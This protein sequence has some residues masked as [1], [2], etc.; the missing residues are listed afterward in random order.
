MYNVAFSFHIRY[1]KYEKIVWEAEAMLHTLMDL[2]LHYYPHLLLIYVLIKTFPA[3]NV[4]IKKI[5]PA[6]CS[7]FLLVLW[8]WIGMRL[9]GQL[10]SGGTE[11]F[12]KSLISLCYIGTAV[13]FAARYLE[14]WFWYKLTLIMMWWFFWGAI[15]SLLFAVAIL[16]KGNE[17]M[18]WI[19][20]ILFENDVFLTIFSVFL[21]WL[22]VSSTIKIP[23]KICV[24]ISVL[25]F[26]V[27]ES[28]IFTDSNM[29]ELRELHFLHKE[30]VIFTLLIS[31]MVFTYYCI[32]LLLKH[33]E[34]LMIQK[35][36][37][38][39][40]KMELQSAEMLFAQNRK[41]SHD[42][43]N[44]MLLLSTLLEQ[45]KYTEATEFF[46]N[47]QSVNSS[48]LNQ[49][50]TGNSIIDVILFRE[51]MK[52]RE[53]GIPFETKVVVPQKLHISEVDISSVL[54]NL[55]DNALEASQNVE[56]PKV[57]LNLRKEQNYILISVE[58]RV[59]EE[60]LEKNPFLETTKGDHVLH[61]NGVKIVQQIALQ[62]DGELKYDQ[63]GDWF[64]AKVMLKDA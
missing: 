28:I 56:N 64:C 9:A 60:I 36:Q 41:F 58:N 29:M 46:K 48:V 61:G 5:L 59:K 30:V 50:S 42:M 20:L 31:V 11:R 47:Y 37:M 54:F 7:Y 19:W 12:A 32:S 4:G 49:S 43:K 44:H 1:H 18:K 14:G 15:R 24:L 16:N 26:V 13:L 39:L 62:N 21:A 2:F 35:H 51:K 38:D 3:K 53:A 8:D 34:T 27:E 23:R 25:C 55:L 17:S 10:F 33:F 63:Q 52:A 57:F 40:Q 45:R 6:G 22:K